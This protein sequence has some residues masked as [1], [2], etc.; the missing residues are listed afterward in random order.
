MEEE[1]EMTGAFI[2]EGSTDLATLLERVAAWETITI[3]RGGVPVALLVP[4]HAVTPRLSHQE[5]VNGMRALRQ[6][7]KPG[8]M[9]VRDMV[10]AGRRF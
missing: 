9:R 3:T 10:N 5:I 8:K 7:V 2:E 6:R 1:M 4:V